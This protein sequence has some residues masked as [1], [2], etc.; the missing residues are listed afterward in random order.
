MKMKKYFCQHTLIT[1]T[2]IFDFAIMNNSDVNLPMP[3][4]TRDNAQLLLTLLTI[5]AS[6]EAKK[7]A[8]TDQSESEDGNKGKGG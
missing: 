5:K 7:K 4:Q 8:L 2:L 3:C 1:Q 6:K